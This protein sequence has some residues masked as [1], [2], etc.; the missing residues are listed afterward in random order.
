[1]ERGITV[2][3]Y[4]TKRH[5]AKAACGPRRQIIVRT[6]KRRALRDAEDAG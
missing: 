3:L 4:G 2:E 5:M 6:V 1:M